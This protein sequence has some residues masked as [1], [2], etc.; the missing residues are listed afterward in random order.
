MGSSSMAFGRRVQTKLLP[1]TIGSA[2][3]LTRFPSLV[4][5]GKVS[6]ASKFAMR[7]PMEFL[8]SITLNNCNALSPS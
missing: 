4:S 7:P 5:M 2:M 3:F 6:Y 8:L 1:S